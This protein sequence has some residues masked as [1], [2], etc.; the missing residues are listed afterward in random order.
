MHLGERGH[1]DGEVPQLP[2]HLDQLDR[3]VESLGMPDPG[4]TG[5]AGRV[6]AQRQHVPHAR[7]GK[8][9]DDLA[10]LVAVCPTQVRWA[11]ASRVVSDAMCSTTRSVR[12]LVVHP[13]AP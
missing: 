4:V 11:T 12:S 9:A 7:G 2:H 5:A 10:Q 6:A 3:V 13:P 8:V 1:A